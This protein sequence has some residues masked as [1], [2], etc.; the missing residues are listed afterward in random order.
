LQ[1]YWFGINSM[2]IQKGDG[3]GF[4]SML[5]DMLSVAIVAFALLVLLAD[6][7]LDGVQR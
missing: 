3:L 6:T 1:F 5:F 2:A 4:L 7:L